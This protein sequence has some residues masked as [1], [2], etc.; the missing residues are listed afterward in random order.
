[1]HRKRLATR[2]DRQAGIP[3]SSLHGASIANR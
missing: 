1:M 3:R 2:I